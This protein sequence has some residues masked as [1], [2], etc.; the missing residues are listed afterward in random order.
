MC[1]ITGVFNVQSEEPVS[2]QIIE[3]MMTVMHHR[4]PDDTGTYF[5]GPVGLGFVRLSIIDLSGGHQP[6]SNETGDIWVVF[7]GEIWNYKTLR[8]DLIAK[9]HHFQ[10]QSDTETIVHAYE[11]YGVDCVR[12]LDGMF[13][14]AIWDAPRQRLFLARDRV[15][16]KPLYYT[17]QN[18][19]FAFASEIKSLLTLPGVSRQVDPQSLAD[20]LS[21]RYVPAPSTLFCD[22]YKVPP[23]HWLV[24]EEGNIRKES[25]WDFQF[26][27]V[28]R[29]PVEQYLNG[30][31][32]HVAR[33]VEARMMADVPV[34]AL[35][36]GGVDSSI[37]T[38]LMSQLTPHRV[39]TFSIGFDMPEYSEL[40]YARRVSEHFG[41]EHH[42]LVVNSSDMAQYWPLL[43][44]HRDEP[45]S[46]PSD[47]GVYL[48]SKLARQHVKV[49][50]SGEGADELFAGYPKY[51]FDWIARYYRWLPEPLRNGLLSPLVNRLPYSMRKQ[52]LA[53][54]AWNQPAPERWMTWFG[55]FNGALKSAILSPNLVSQVDMDASRTFRH[56]LE[57]HPQR[58]D[59]SSMLY[60]DTKLWLP[61]NLLM[62]ADKMTMA[63]SVESRI[64][65]LDAQLIEYAA[66][67]PSDLK[68]RSFQ[69]KALFKQAF[70][71][72]LP[73]EVL[74][75]KKVGFT[76]PTGAWFRGPQRDMMQDLLLSDRTLDRGYL[77]PSTV[78]MMVHDHLVGKTNYQNPLFIL[79]SLELWFRVFIDPSHLQ[80]PE[81][82]PEAMT[83]AT[84]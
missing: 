35:L 23:G 48:I 9:G 14:F 7:N 8:Q 79:A 34:G 12:H 41:T 68:I 66:T 78:R 74:S 40:P 65:L 84:A 15:G 55:I 28:E 71:S 39:K 10:T 60:L 17:R 37:V 6:M 22:I 32:S 43:T 81:A 83:A 20:Y 58:D 29:Q 61:D 36:S 1:G 4:G 47:L 75:R 33:A 26:G 62:K 64:P 70:A 80:P 30:I 49:V 51:A 21:V 52:Q 25:Y 76:V 38:G 19:N 27:P 16:K 2:P 56:V 53:M 67:I 57:A 18:G 77:N 13:A 46:E 54:T 72:L 24:V 42:E 45:V 63:A 11:T 69:T 50:L 3:R 59:L 5:D 44:W 73:P 82:H 31:R